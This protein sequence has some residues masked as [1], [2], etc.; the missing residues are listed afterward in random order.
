MSNQWTAPGEG[1]P[2][3]PLAQ[4]P[5]GAPGPW[6]QAPLPPGTP[7][8]PPGTPVPPP[9]SPVPLPGAPMG[10]P[11]AS[12][13]QGPAWATPPR[14]GIIALRPLTLS[15]LFDGSF[16][17]VRTN[18]TVFFG[19]ALAVNA[20]L[21][22]VNALVT[23]FL[24]NSVFDAVSR[25]DYRSANDVFGML[26]GLTTQFIT[27][28]GLTAA[29]SFVG[30]TLVSGMLC[31]AVI[32][33]AAGRKP[34]LGQTWRRLA[35]RFWPLVAT[36]L[37]TGILLILIAIVLALVGLV[38][39]AALAGAISST[40]GGMGAVAAIGLI[41]LAL[42]AVLVFAQ[43]CFAVRFL[44]APAATVI[45]GRSG[46]GAIGRSWELTQ[47]RWMRSVGRY[48]L[49]VLLSMVA[50]WIVS[51]GVSSVLDMSVFATAVDGTVS[52]A[53]VK[54]AVSTAVMTVLQSLVTPLVTS[55]ILLM[56]LDERIRRENFAATLAAAA[57]G[58]Q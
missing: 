56:Y 31:V 6:G 55:Y 2:Q 34:T 7:V 21:A 3:N 42:I 54:Q 45:E 23:W 5:A 1:E 50:M 44:Y 40:R 47:G 49:I 25:T 27:S 58:N 26:G 28:W 14:P 10:G 11:G 19:F 17:A 36:T 13:G 12:Y 38:V 15:D 48:L 29:A 41:F 57:A 16:K 9:G 22:V 32:E 20:I 18:P 37:L 53:V 52:A 33:A 4:G 8:P 30:S 46:F 43:F 39:I 24:I 35:P 51:L